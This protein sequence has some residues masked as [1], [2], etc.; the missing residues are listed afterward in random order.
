MV[1]TQKIKTEHGVNHM[2]KKKR[3]PRR[4]HSKLWEKKM[5]HLQLKELKEIS[6]KWA[7][8]LGPLQ[9]CPGP[10]LQCS[11]YSLPVNEDGVLALHIL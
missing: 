6:S 5:K 9:D 11:P 2:F 1:N 4:R 7:Q 3:R 10:L 8:E